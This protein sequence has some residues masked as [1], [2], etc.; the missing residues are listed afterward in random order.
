M[1]FLREPLT[2]AIIVSHPSPLGLPCEQRCHGKYISPPKMLP[3]HI[4]NYGRI[5]ALRGWVGGGSG[6]GGLLCTTSL[7]SSAFGLCCGSYRPP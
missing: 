3:H 7:R 1:R 4:R 5:P 6:C 2:C